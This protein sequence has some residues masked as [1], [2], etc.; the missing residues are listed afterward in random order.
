MLR[1]VCVTALAAAPSLAEEG[2]T[3][4]CAATSRRS[5]DPATGTAADLAP[6]AACGAPA[7][8]SAPPFRVIRLPPGS[9]LVGTTEPHF[10]EDVEGPP[11]PWSLAAPLW[12]DAFEV[13]VARFAGFA[14]ATGYV[15]EAHSFGWSF[16]HENA[17]HPDTLAGISQSVKGAEWWVPVPNASWRFPRGLLHGDALATGLA[18]HPALHIS[19]GDGDAFCGW[20]GGR[21][22]SEAEW[23]YAAHGGGPSEHRFPWGNGPKVY[24]K[25]AEG[26]TIY[27]TNIWQ[28]GFPYENTGADGN[29]WSSRVDAYGPQNAWGLYNIIG[30]AWEWTADEWCPE[31][32]GGATIA[33]Q[34]PLPPDCKHRT[35]AAMAAAARDSGEVEYVKKGGSFM[36]HKSFCYRYRVHARHHNTA[37]SGAQNLGLRCVYDKLPIDPLGGAVEEV[38]AAG[39]SGGGEEEG[40]AG[41][42]GG[43]PAAAR[44]PATAAGG[45]KK[46]K[47]GGKG[48]KGK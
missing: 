27:R 15:S 14:S 12:V 46:G 32:R 29:L 47:K 38:V 30:N 33:S 34:R 28:G 35:P 42:E 17:T 5:V 36:C 7:P 24:E 39:F 25:D 10:P 2:S 23:E 31:R 37:N 21:L 11:I 13:S 4:G 44:A 41:G 1:L 20:A 45:K 19:K 16:V 3:C 8:P 22:P 6:D 43:A 48:G 40:G 18:H 9:T 26:G